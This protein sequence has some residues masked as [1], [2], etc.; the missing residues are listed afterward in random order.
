MK[1]LS[2]LI[3]NNIILFYFKMSSVEVKLLRK[4]R[5]WDLQDREMFSSA[6]IIDLTMLLTGNVDPQDLHQ[7]C[8]ADFKG[9]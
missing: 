6:S 5:R 8:T 3:L 4:N 1:N 7:V 2:N 9:F